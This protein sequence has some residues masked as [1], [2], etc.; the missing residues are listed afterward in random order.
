M[1]GR[2]G[3]V[4]QSGAEC[5]RARLCVWRSAAV[6]V[7]G[8]FVCACQTNQTASSARPGSDATVAFES[9]DGPPPEVFRKLVQK[10][11]AEAE[12]K[13]VPVVSHAH[14][15]PY[16]IRGYVALGIEKKKK[17]THVSWVWDVYDANQRRTVRFSGEEIAGPAGRDP[18]HAA[19]D[20]VLT[21]IAR[22]GM[23][24]L[25]AYFGPSAGAPAESPDAAPVM[26]APAAGAVVAAA[27]P[28]TGAAIPLSDRRPATRRDGRVAAIVPD[29]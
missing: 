16:R 2:H 4:M 22:T 9:I 13:N 14:T 10:L 17:R 20:E 29:R 19:N 15:A 27:E 26:P 7:L 28:E 12:A 1:S 24:R 6:A 18:W 5:A 8:L 23:E 3:D 11:N 21:R 25:A